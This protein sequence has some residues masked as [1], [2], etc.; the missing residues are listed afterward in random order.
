MSFP[1][2]ARSWTAAGLATWSLACTTGRAEIAARPCA[3]PPPAARTASVAAPRPTAQRAAASVSAEPAIDALVAIHGETHRA[4]I[5]RGVRQV[6]RAWRP[7]D[8]DLGAFAVAHYVADPQQRATLLERLRAAFEQLDG[9]LNEIGRALRSATDLDVGPLLPADKVLAAL[10]VGAHL[11]ED[12]FR[13]KVAFIALLNFPLTTLDERMSRADALSRRDWAELRLAGRFASRVPAEVRQAQAQALADADVY[14]AEYNL[15]MHHVV[16]PSGARPF[17]KGKRLISHWNLRD[18]LKAAYDEP[19]GLEKQRI[20]VRVMQHIV[21]QTIPAAVIDDPRIDWEPFANVVTAAPAETVEPDAPTRP[22]ATP[23]T[24][25]REDDVRYRH[26]LAN[27]HAQRAADP[28]YPTAPDAIRRAYELGQE[29]PEARVRAMLEAV[30]ASPLVPRMAAEA[31]RRLGRPLEP[32]DLWYKGFVPR[33][34]L[35]EDQ[36]DA[37]TRERYPTADAF[38]ADMPRILVALG[39]PKARARYLAER[40]AVDPSRGAGHAMQAMRRGDK[41]HLRTRVEK[42]GMNYKGYNIAVHELGHNVEQTFSLYDVDSTLLAG[43]PNN[44]FTEALAF[45]FQ[46]RDLELLGV[47]KPDPEAD[48]ERTLAAFWAAWEIAGV[49][50]VD[51]D[52]WHWMYA[53]PDATPAEVR[54]ATVEIAARTWDRWYAPVLGGQGTVLLGIY[55]HMISYPLYLSAYPV[56]RF[57]A[58]QLEATFAKAGKV[59]PEFERVTKQGAVLPDVWMKNA[60]GAPVGAEPLLEAAARALDALDAKA[61]KAGAAPRPSGAKK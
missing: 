40:I 2:S 49:A 28:H 8:G 6:A 51:T 24:N 20:L 26:L 12:L 53:H 38:A 18:E 5:T 19:A 42:D 3:E 57:I 1:R 9:S 31:Q 47:M 25:A 50:L 52:V 36:L 37:L 56:G 54:A 14:I 48:R 10:D 11:G 41:A 35:A 27:F 61:S 23:L 46:A 15:W 39:F 45:V 59:G 34:K 43:V 22:L 4:V 33:P 32:A 60:S 44:A 30:L 16:T 29:L 13:S 17:P 7:E 58:A 55:S 21:E